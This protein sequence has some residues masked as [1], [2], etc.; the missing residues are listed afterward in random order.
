MSQN[1]D[2]AKK[3]GGFSAWALNQSCISYKTKINSRTVK[4]EMNWAGAWF[5]TG[6]QDVEGNEDGGV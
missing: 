3:W 6:G 1:N 4:G 5:A 2:S